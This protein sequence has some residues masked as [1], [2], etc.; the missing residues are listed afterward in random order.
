VITVVIVDDHQ[1]VRAG[2]R[3]LLDAV[4]DVCVVGEAADG[5]QAVEVVQ[6][7]DPD[8]TLMDLSMPRVDGVEAARRLNAA[9]AETRIVVLTS[10]TDR[11]R[12][13]AAVAAGAVGYI[14]KDS[15]PRDVIDAVRRAA[16]GQVPIDPRVA[17]ALLPGASLSDPGSA[18]RPR[19]REVLGLVAEG[20][21]NKQIARALSISERTVKA[22]LGSVF[23]KIGVTDRTSAALW[24]KENL[25]GGR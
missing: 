14:L 17:S 4:E 16:A 11:D 6:R 15:D 22:H 1:L 24:A 20:L 3:S 7:E 10:F 9:G 12:V 2:L 13:T 8:V 21:A 19:E 5:E 23:S 25:G 18:L